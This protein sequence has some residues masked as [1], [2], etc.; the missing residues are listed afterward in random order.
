M[1]H[2]VRLIGVKKEDTTGVPSEATKD[3]LAAKPYAWLV[4]FAGT[5]E[6]DWKASE[7]KLARETLGAAA[8]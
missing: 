8:A 5:K 2:P 1:P 7:E 3:E 6:I 4:K